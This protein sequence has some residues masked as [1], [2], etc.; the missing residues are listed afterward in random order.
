MTSTLDT[1]ATA[2]TDATPIPFTLTFSGT[3]LD[4]TEDRIQ[5]E[6]GTLVDFQQFVDP[7]DP[8]G[9]L[10]SASVFTFA[11]TPADNGTVTVTI[12]TC[13]A[14][15][16]TT[17]SSYQG[18]ESDIEFNGFP[19]ATL[20]TEVLS[21][22]DA[23]AVVVTAS[24]NRPVTG[25]EPGDVLAANA[26]ITGFQEITPGLAYELTVVPTAP[27]P[28]A[29]VVPGGAALDAANGLG[30]LAATCGF[31]S[32]ASFTIERVNLNTFRV[33]FNRP[34]AN[35]LSVFS[36]TFSPALDVLGV[37]EES[38]GVYRVQTSDQTL[39]TAYSLTVGGVEGTDG[40]VGDKTEEFL[41]GEFTVAFTDG[42]GNPIFIGQSTAADD[43]LGDGFDQEGDPG[44]GDLPIVRIL[45]TTGD[46]GAD[47]LTCDIR[48]DDGSTER[49][50]IEVIFPTAQR[51]SWT[52]SWQLGAVD[53]NRLV[54]LQ[55]LRDNA[56][57]GSPVDMT[58][59]DQIELSTDTVFEILSGPAE[60]IPLQFRKGWNLVGTPLVTL[61]SA[62]ESATGDSQDCLLGSS[63]I[64]RL[65]QGA[66]E[67]GSADEPL[68]AESGYWV[69]AAADGVAQ[70]TCGLRDDGTV[71][72]HQGWN[73]ISPTTT[74][75]LGDLST[76]LT[77]W[78]WDAAALCYRLLGAEDELVPG[79]GYWVY[80]T[81]AQL[82][83]FPDPATR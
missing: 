83:Q 1:T 21:P 18:T 12:P 49:W 10:L 9:G 82:I 57:Y 73:L 63:E 17:L 14:D 51:G 41:P 29:V 19:V 59:L 62:R 42:D 28:V 38:P 24:F 52:F 6:N 36:Y 79:T 81:E 15:G 44:D 61:M 2:P 11:V 70:A 43:G 25:F 23:D 58:G 34:V 3:V 48:L 35:P 50:F 67:T 56:P 80:T 47:F 16:F 8:F 74:C 76:S 39:G 78:R 5:V 40:V 4:F 68:L 7:D 37:V 65:V 26:T 45:N 75:A 72:L 31:E 64:L 22:T 55:E 20:E 27:G 33:R 66:Y 71:Q 46:G 30:S 53:G 69:R 32:I 77:V 13:A 54:L 60:E